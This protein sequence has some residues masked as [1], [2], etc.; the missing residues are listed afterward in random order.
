MEKFNLELDSLEGNVLENLLNEI[1][2]NTNREGKSTITLEIDQDQRDQLID[3]AFALDYHNRCTGTCMN[4]TKIRAAALKMLLKQVVDSKEY[5]E[6][7]YYYK[8]KLSGEDVCNIM[9]IKKEIEITQSRMM[10]EETK[11]SL[12]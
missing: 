9:D 3:V 8:G 6:P 4:L 11:N 2:V 10:F 12:L 1:I 7:F 5:K